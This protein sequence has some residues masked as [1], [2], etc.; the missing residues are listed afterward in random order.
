VWTDIFLENRAAL[1]TELENFQAGLQRMA[2]ALAASDA[3]AL[4]AAI[5]QAAE[6]R[7]RM[8]TAGSLAPGELFRLVIKIPDRPGVIREITVA[9]GDANINI[10]DMALHHMSAELGGALTVYVT[11]GDV[12]RRGA[13]LLEGLGYEVIT[14]RAVE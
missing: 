10:E 12:C 9:L 14:G 6:H 5:G 7:A 13:E 1:L 2:E 11:G 4:G 3:E 8:L